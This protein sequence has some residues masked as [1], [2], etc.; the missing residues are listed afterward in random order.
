LSM[1]QA[2]RFTVCSG[3]RSPRSHPNAS[4]YACIFR[5]NT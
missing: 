4:V 2:L 5:L 3:M 1:A